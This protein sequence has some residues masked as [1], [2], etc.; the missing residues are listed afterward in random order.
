MALELVTMIKHDEQLA[1]IYVDVVNGTVVGAQVNNEIGRSVAVTF[2]TPTG[3][4]VV[5]ATLPPGTRTYNLPKPRQFP[6][7]DDTWSVSLTSRP[8]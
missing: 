2:T 3:F 1:T 7:A 4:S 6:Y 5:D 8:T